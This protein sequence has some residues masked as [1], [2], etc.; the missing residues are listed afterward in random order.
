M[1]A[2]RLEPFPSIIPR[3]GDTPALWQYV[4][5]VMGSDL[6]PEDASPQARLLRFTQEFAPA[7]NAV[8]PTTCEIQLESWH[9]TEVAVAERRHT[10]A[11]P[12]DLNGAV[13][14]VLYSGGRFLVDGCNRVNSWLRHGNQEFHNVV[15]IRH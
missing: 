1:A 4:Y 11:R 7:C 6:P 3:P 9:M 12:R 5:E 13:I 2:R 15:V 8:D 10:R 14:V